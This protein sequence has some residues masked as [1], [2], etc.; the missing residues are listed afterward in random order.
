MDKRLEL[1]EI[2]INL[3][4][5]NNVYYQSPEDM[6]INYPCIRYSKDDINSIYA[7]NKKYLNKKLYILIIIDRLPD[8][9]VI[10][11]ILELPLT[12]Y[13]RHY[14]SDNLN[15]DVINIYY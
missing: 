5:N 11:K 1:H 6:K 3:L 15:H 8:N 2:L 10:D 12:S 14:T 4:G 7:D 13:E 9:P